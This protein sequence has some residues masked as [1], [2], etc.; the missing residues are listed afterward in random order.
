MIYRLEP[1]FKY[2]L[3]GGAVPDIDEERGGRGGDGAWK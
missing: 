2:A 1:A 3:N